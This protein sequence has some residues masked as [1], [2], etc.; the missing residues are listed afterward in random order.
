MAALGGE[1]PT[2]SRPTTHSMPCWH[3]TAQHLQARHIRVR[4]YVQSDSRAGTTNLVMNT[5][6]LHQQLRAAGRL[7]RVKVVGFW[8][9]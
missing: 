7:V 9:Q 4:P 6:P 3:Q 1:Q 8:L 5:S 2:A